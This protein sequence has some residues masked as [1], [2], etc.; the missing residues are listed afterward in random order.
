MYLFT[1]TGQRLIVLP[2]MNAIRSDAQQ[3]KIRQR[4]TR[5]T[6]QFIFGRKQ[7]HAFFQ[8]SV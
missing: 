2:E 3:M 1:G 8:F 6:S 7:R 5:E 4:A